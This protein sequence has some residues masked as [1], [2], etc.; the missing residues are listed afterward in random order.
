MNDKL[1][2]SLVCGFQC[3]WIMVTCSVKVIN[4]IIPFLRRG[5]IYTEAT[6]LAKVPELLGTEIWLT[7]ETYLID[8]IGKV[9]DL[10]RK[11]KKIL[12]IANN[13]IAEFKAETE[14]YAVKDFDYQIG[15]FE[16]KKI[17]KACLNSYGE[18]T[19][20]EKSPTEKIEIETQIAAEYQSFFSDKTRAFKKSPHLLNSMKQFLSDNFDL[21]EG[22]L[23]KLYHPS[24]ID[25]YPPAEEKYYED[26]QKAFN[27]T[28][29]PKYRRI[30]KS[31]G[32]AGHA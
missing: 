32:Y 1:I 30:Q 6:L 8:N 20:N 16:E 9:I 12:G 24:Q 10:N 18:N 25:I 4:N 21:T 11:Q 31:N 15:D 28:W 22:Q 29:Q 3:Q 2:S 19:W 5:L 17:V 13:L 23:R 7:N 26:Q 27:I 14:K